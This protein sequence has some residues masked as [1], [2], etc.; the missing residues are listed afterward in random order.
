MNGEAVKELASR[1]RAPVELGGFLIR[2]NDWV[3]DDPAALVKSG[4][5]AKVLDVT[6]LGAVRD[7]L[8]ANRDALA[9]DRL[10][11]H[12][13]SPALVWIG[14]PILDRS[15]AR[16]FYLQAKALDLSDGFLG[17]FM[18]VEEFLI[19]LQVRFADLDDRR[20]LLA[21]L[22]NVKHETVKTAL[23]DG[24]TQVVQ[25]RAG[26][27]LVSDVAVPNPVLLSPFRTFRDVVQP[28]SLFVV[29]VNSG[30]TG[31]LPEVGLF[32]AD[33]GAWRLS[34][35]ERVREWLE[36]ELSEDVAIL[37]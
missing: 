34:A 2:P 1:F 25:A 36:R 23:D 29:R 10:I 24:V 17:R 9:L 8:K 15:R 18:A 27:A 16:E 37:G 14:G 20:R 4:P 5:L 30:R 26:V 35:T 6:T 33:G 12:V 7:Y 22:S 19:G 31:G 21:L 13:A 11:V 32:E 3:V 28:S